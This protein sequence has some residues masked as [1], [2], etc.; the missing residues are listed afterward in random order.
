MPGTLGAAPAPT[1][2]STPQRLGR[3]YPAPVDSHPLRATGA[4]TV[5]RLGGVSTSIARPSEDRPGAHATRACAPGRSSDGR[6]MDVETPP[7]RGTVGGSPWCRSGWCPPEPGTDAP[8]A[9]RAARG[10]CR[11]GTQRPR[12]RCLH[13]RAEL[14]RVSRAASAEWAPPSWP[15]AVPATV[16]TREGATAAAPLAHEVNRIRV[17]HAM[18][19]RPP[20]RVHFRCESPSREEGMAC[21]TRTRERLEFDVE[22][23]VKVYTTGDILAVGGPDARPRRVLRHRRGHGRGSS[24]AAPSAA[25]SRTAEPSS[26]TNDGWPLPFRNRAAG[27]RAEGDVTYGNGVLVAALPLAAEVRPASD[28]RARRFCTWRAAPDPRTAER[29]RDGGRRPATRPTTLATMGS[30]CGRDRAA[31]QRGARSTRTRR[32]GRRVGWES[33]QPFGP[34]LAAAGEQRDQNPDCDDP[35]GAS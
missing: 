16:A 26:S 11:R 14:Q 35:C 19:M 13:R 23:Q 18:S 5:P 29:P 32:P 28:P 20:V 34:C 6:A 10:R 9:R 2:G 30:G 21:G 3:R 15:P 22:T 33:G 24:S 1:S 31:G 8:G 25:V 7:R 17:G 4:A 12:R 27:R